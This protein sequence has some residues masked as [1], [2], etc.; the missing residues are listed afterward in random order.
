MGCGEVVSRNV[1]RTY[2]PGASADWE[3]DLETSGRIA[4][5]S[6]S[7]SVRVK[8]GIK[9]GSILSSLVFSLVFVAGC[10]EEPAPTTPGPGGGG[11]TPA[12][13]PSDKPATPPPITP[14]TDEKKPG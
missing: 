14:K 2:G 5:F 9:V 12:P 7:A 10:N 3:N 6:R 1:S 13:K 8:F 4:C 11:V